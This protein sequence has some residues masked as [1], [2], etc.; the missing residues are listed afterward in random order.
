MELVAIV[1]NADDKAGACKAAVDAFDNAYREAQADP[2]SEAA[3]AVR[4]VRKS[5]LKTVLEAAIG[6]AGFMDEVEAAPGNIQRLAKMARQAKKGG[7]AADDKE[8]VDP[9]Q[10]ALEKALSVADK[11]GYAHVVDALNEILRAGW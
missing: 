7:V 8:P 2:D 5:E 4:K 3:K 11:A 1:A 9:M 6:V 10:A